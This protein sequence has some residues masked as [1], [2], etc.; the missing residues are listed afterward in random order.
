MLRFLSVRQ[1]IIMEAVEVEFQPGFTVVTGETGAG[2]SILMDA[3]GFALGHRVAGAD[4][5][6]AQVTLEASV[7]PDVQAILESQGLL[8]AE[9]PDTL[10]LRRIITSE[11]RSRCF[12]N[13]TSVSLATQKELGAMLVSFHH[14]DDRVIEPR[15]QR[16]LLDAYAETASYRG[17]LS[18]A[19]G[20]W[21][22]AAMSHATLVALIQKAAQ[23]LE[24]WQ[25]SLSELKSFSPTADEETLLLEERSRFREREG[26][27]SAL[28]KA[29]ESLGGAPSLEERL[30]QVMRALEPI[31]G[32]APLILDV[33]SALE[34]CHRVGR[35]LTDRQNDLMSG[36]FHHPDEIEARIFELRRLAR[37][38]AVP[39]GDL[40][41]LQGR[42]QDWVTTAQ[43]QEEA[44]PKSAAALSET[45]DAYLRAA[46]RLSDVRREKALALAAAVHERLPAL[47]LGNARLRLDFKE[48]LESDWNADGI[49]VLEFYVQ[50]NPGS[51]E[52]PLKQ[53]AS[54][55][56]RAR[57]L[58]A[59][60]AAT[61]HVQDRP[62]L[63]F[64]EI[65]QGVGGSVAEAMGLALSDLAKGR[66]VIAITHAPQVAAVG[67]VHLVIEKQHAAGATHMG[68]R[69]LTADERVEELARM[70]SGHDITPA[71]RHMAQQLLGAHKGGK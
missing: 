34:T 21:Q 38:H 23:D 13:G 71:S 36:G 39:P 26:A 69:R 6:G 9:A 57:L 61:A 16:D 60:K 44:L 59:L 48:K 4:K 49:D 37:K 20:A 30:H 64:D 66:Q 32:A 43:S 18:D 28:K 58:L 10:L 45:R 12:V 33:E 62:T 7:S 54:G 3:L 15:H 1:F 55:G 46:R 2:K 47:K 31:E 29:V 35:F 52:G 19:Y 50:T 40:A 65:D 17:A 22:R 68:L 51:P 63:I 56:E 67:D 70:V 5:P 53:V 41:A 25:E 14:Q 42:L 27:Q 24:Y 11:G 8:D